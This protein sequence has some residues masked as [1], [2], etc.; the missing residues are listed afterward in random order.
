MADE[1]AAR[2]LFM[3]DGTVVYPDS[4]EKSDLGTKKA[5]QLLLA[6]SCFT[7]GLLLIYLCFLNLF[8]D[9]TDLI[10]F[11]EI[12]KTVSITKIHVERC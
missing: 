1:R 11:D 2:T 8:E 4:C 7:N 5:A 6:A 9:L 12:V 10:C 3:S